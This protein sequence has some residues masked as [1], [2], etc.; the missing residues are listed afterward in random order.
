MSSYSQIYLNKKKN[1]IKKRKNINQT[2]NDINKDF[3]NEFNISNQDNG[4]KL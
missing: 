2:Y 1:E 4:S 3:S